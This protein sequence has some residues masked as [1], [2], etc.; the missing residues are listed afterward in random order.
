MVPSVREMRWVS[1]GVCLAGAG[2]AVEQHAALQVAA[3]FAEGVSVF[4]DA[5]HVS[6]DAV[7]NPVGQHDV[8]LGDRRTFD[9]DG[10]RGPAVVVATAEADH[11]ATQ[12]TAR[13]H[14]APNLAEQSACGCRVCGQHVQLR[15][16][17]PVVRSGGH[18]QHDD[19]RLLE[20]K[21]PQPKSHHLML[22]L[23]SGRRFDVVDRAGL[24]GKM[25]IHQ[26][27]ADRV[28]TGHLG[29]TDTEQSGVWIRCRQ[30]A[31][32]Q[33]D[34]DE[35]VAGHV[36]AH[37][38]QVKHLD[39]EV[40]LNDLAERRQSAHPALSVDALEELPERLDKCLL[41]FVHAVILPIVSSKMFR[42]TVGRP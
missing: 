19:R 4:A 36:L 21:Q 20:L 33:V 22:A 11:L 35:S 17:L 42:P 1:D 13:L 2:R 8:G 26:Q 15:V 32:R 29:A 9:E 37:R 25:R 6:D 30:F 18:L 5:D 41:L 27:L 28:Q 10:P 14:Q 38:R 23:R 7:Q 3:G 12:H 40:S 39:A 31:Q 34:V 24:E 16:F